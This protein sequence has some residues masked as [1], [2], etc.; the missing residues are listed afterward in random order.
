MLVLGDDGLGVGGGILESLQGTG[1]IQ[2]GIKSC[3]NLNEQKNEPLRTPCIT[4]DGAIT[5]AI[6]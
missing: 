4:L 3:S 5:I 6:L 1:I 2:I